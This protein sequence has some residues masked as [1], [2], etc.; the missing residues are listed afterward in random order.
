MLLFIYGDDTEFR[1]IQK[2]NH[3]EVPMI[4][5]EQTQFELYKTMMFPYVYYLSDQ[6]IVLAQ[7]TVNTVEK[8][9]VIV[10]K[11]IK[12]IENVQ[13]TGTGGKME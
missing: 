13:F 5:Y 9:D 3:F 1:K 10:N 8:V 12:G 11:G 7:D 4:P 2:E 6:G